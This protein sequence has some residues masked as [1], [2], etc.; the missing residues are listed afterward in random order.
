MIPK[1]ARSVE[2]GEAA[3]ECKRQR[4]EITGSN[5]IEQQSGKPNFPPEMVLEIINR[6][7]VKSV[8]RF[9]S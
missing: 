1:R 6:V 5:S 9:G 8:I 2:E 3:D 4:M 7:P